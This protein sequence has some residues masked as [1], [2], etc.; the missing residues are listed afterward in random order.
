MTPLRLLQCVLV[1]PFQLVHAVGSP[2]FIVATI[3]T[4]CTQA[5]TVEIFCPDFDTE[6]ST[7]K[8]LSCCIWFV[9]E[10]LT[11]FGPD[12]CSCMTHDACHGLS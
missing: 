6:N 8:Y 1:H 2:V 3:T 4:A 12:G 11:G 10:V 5:S 9:H 7:R